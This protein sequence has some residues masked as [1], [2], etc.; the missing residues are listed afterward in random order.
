MQDDGNLVLYS[1]TNKAIWAS[2]TAGKN[3]DTPNKSWMSS[4][5]NRGY[6]IYT[7]D[8]LNNGDFLCSKN[9]QVIASLWNGSFIYQNFTNCMK[10]WKNIWWSMDKCCI[11]N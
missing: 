1:K 3:G 7:G 6:V 4:S 10:K 2:N 11:Y 9:G 8:R 5:N